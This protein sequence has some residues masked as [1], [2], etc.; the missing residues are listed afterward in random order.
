VSTRRKGK[1][2]ADK[3]KPAKAK[4]TAVAKPPNS[5]QGKAKVMPTKTAT[6]V[7]KKAATNGGGHRIADEDKIKIVAKENP[8]RSGTKLYNYFKKYK[9]GMTVAAAK[10]AGIPPKNIAYLASQDLIKVVAA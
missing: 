8:H 3:A 5:K 4:T 9:D 6:K 10:K 1:S 7:A 2:S